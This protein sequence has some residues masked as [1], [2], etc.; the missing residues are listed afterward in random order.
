M[1]ARDTFRTAA[2]GI[3]ALLF[4]FASVHATDPSVDVR[5]YRGTVR[6]TPAQ[7]R[8]EGDVHVLVRNAG[9]AAVSTLDLDLVN[10][11]VSEVSIAGSAAS[12]E[13]D[14]AVLRVTLPAALAAGDS[15]EVR[16]RYSGN[17]GNEGGTQPWGGCQW[18][19][20]SYF[21]GVGF[22]APS[23][24][25]MRLWM[26]S[27]D[28]PSDKASFDITFEV[29]EG[30]A[31]AGTGVL[32][33]RDGDGTISRWRWVERHPTATYLFTYA[34]STYAL[35]ED[36][37]N[38]VP[39]WYFVP[40]A[41]SARAAGYFSTV[42]GM[43]DAFTTAF[44]P[45]PFDKVGY[46]ITPIGSM[47]HQTMIS[48]AQQLF[49]TESVA[50][51]TAAHELAHMWWG[52]WVTC[53]D[54]GDA[55]LNEGFAVFGEM[56][57]AEHRGGMAAYLDFVRG[58]VQLYRTQ[59]VQL[60]GMLPLHDFPRNPPSS[61]YPYTIY[62]KGGVVLA[63]L[64]DVMGDDAFFEGLRAYG[65]AHAYDVASTESFRGVMEQHYGAD[66]GWFFDP[67]VYK[68]GYPSYLLQ[69]V[70]DASDAPL[71][72]WLLQ[73]QDTLLYPLYAM[74]MDLAII[75]SSGDTLL[76]RI[77]SPAAALHE[78]TFADIPANTVQNVV[79]DPRG[80]VLKRVV[81]RP[82][83]VVD[84]SAALPSGLRMHATH[85]NPVTDR[86]T[87]QYTVAQSVAL[88]LRIF[89]AAGR[90]VHR[91]ALGRVDAGT[92]ALEF[93]TGNLPAGVYTA[94]LQ[95]RNGSASTHFLIA[96]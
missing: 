92:H 51:S 62:K 89:D 5:S 48:Y 14:N 30:L 25:L 27:N 18:G 10:M 76:R 59:I 77:E 44:G 6:I 71:R 85:P 50:G 47:E 38:G 61:N 67:W 11:T 34:I 54:F 31:V 33:S 20:I 12:F 57:Y 83:A 81:Y 94:I 73:T 74:P 9:S 78:F 49:T 66:L 45:Y 24:S 84:A 63:M 28:I 36:T 58:T 42:P 55:W 8:V 68:P 17:P 64:R 82:T 39:L 21:M 43:M 32:A 15:V 96:R 60:E 40:R 1:N 79:L 3:F 91:R 90:V 13:H 65:R 56:V 26:P 19:N 2:L 87:L 35:V 75:R 70:I 29:P 69:R 93:D 52:D 88:D 95:G 4:L 72:V 86:G 16:V 23:V 7:Q 41:D 53:A 22:S 80:I 37:W 46:C